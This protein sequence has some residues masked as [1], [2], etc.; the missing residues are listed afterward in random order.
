M[1]AF[2]QEE[3]K[4]AS[5]I[6][7]EPLFEETLSLKNLEECVLGGIEFLDDGDSNWTV[8]VPRP[9]GGDGAR[10]DGPAADSALR[11]GV[12]AVVDYVV[13]VVRDGDSAWTVQVPCDAGGDGARGDGPAADN[14]P[15]DG[16]SV[17]VGYVRD[18]V[19]DC[20]SAWTVQVPGDAGGDGARGDGPANDR[21]QR[22]R[23]AVCN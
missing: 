14:A 9:N 22:H 3:E 13:D 23:R 5:I 12:S 11:D 7:F 10:G 19:R 2:L 18:V 21:A 4:K 16:A 8:Q 20:H 6:L 1:Q 17:V 15:R